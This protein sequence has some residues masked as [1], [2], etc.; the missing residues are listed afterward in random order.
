VA[1]VVAAEADQLRVGQVQG[2]DAPVGGGDPQVITRRVHNRLGGALLVVVEGEPLAR[3]VDDLSQQCDA[4]AAG[5]GEVPDTAGFGVGDRVVAVGVDGQRVALAG[6]G[7]DRHAGRGV[8]VGQQGAVLAD[9]DHALGVDLQALV[10]RRRPLRAEPAARPV[11]RLELAGEDQRQLRGEGHIRLGQG[12]A[13]G[14]HVDRVAAEDLAQQFP[15]RVA[16]RGGHAVACAR[17]QPTLGEGASRIPQ[18]RLA[19]ASGALAADHVGDGVAERVARVA[20]P[21]GAQDRHG[22]AFGVGGGADQAREEHG[23]VLAPLAGV[24]E[25]VGVQRVDRAGQLHHLRAALEE[26]A[27]DVCRVQLGADEQVRR[28]RAQSVGELR[29]GRGLLQGVGYSVPGVVGGVGALAAG[30]GQE[31]L[32]LL[33]AGLADRCRAG[34]GTGALR[35]LDPFRTPNPGVQASHRARVLIP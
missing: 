8:R 33:A 34:V 1:V 3:A 20:S 35:I 15:G 29:L 21:A 12:H 28:A 25:V 31:L 19:H 4:V 22:Q 13:A 7:Q 18:G 26:A 30:V 6:Q 24:G 9:E 2:R 32:G 17:L 27:Q 10:G 16:Q 5:T 11:R 23:G 14:G